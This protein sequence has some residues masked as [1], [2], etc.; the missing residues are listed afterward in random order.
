MIEVGAG[1]R[2]SP[3]AAGSRIDTVTQTCARALPP[4]YRI[5]EYEIV[6]VLGAGGFGITYLANDT[7]LDGPVALKEYFPHEH[8]ERTAGQHVAALPTEESRALFTWGL[9]RFVD[10]ARSI[11]RFRHPNVVRV[12][13]YVEALG[14]ACIVME[15]V[16]GESLDAVLRTRAPLPAAEWRQWLDRLLDGLE[17]VHGHGYVHRDITP[18]NIV[19]RAANGEPVFIDFA[20]ARA[21]ARGRAHTQVLTPRYA[22]I[23]QHGTE[24]AQGPPTDIY[25]LA[26]VSY[27]A[28]T[29][30]C[31][32]E[33]PARAVDD[34]YEPLA[35]RVAGADLPWLAAIDRGMA[36]RPDDRPRTVSAW[37]SAMAG[38][39][40]PERAPDE[41]AAVSV[42][43]LAGD[44]EALRAS[45]ARHTF[46]GI[47]FGTS[48]TVV[49]IARMDDG[50]RVP[51]AEPLS[52]PQ[53][54][55]DGRRH[56]DHLVP[57]CL[58][59]RNG[60]LLVGRGVTTHLKARLREGVDHWSSFK[61]ELGVDL[62]PQYPNTVLAKGRAPVV[63]ERPQDA[64]RVFLSH[65]RE[66]VD[67]HVLDHSLPPPVYAVSVPAAFEANQR[68]DLV[69]ALDGAGIPVEDAGL[70][71]E[72]NAAFLSYV[73][74]MERGAEGPSVAALLP[75]K[76][77][78]VL[79]FDF[80]AG[81]CDISVLEVS[82]A[83]GRLSSRNLAISKFLALGGD[84][85]DRAIAERML[86]FQLRGDADPD[87]V[88]SSNER[89]KLLLPRLKSVAEEL[90]IQCSKQAEAMK[91]GDPSDLRDC[92]DPIV[93]DPIEAIEVRGK[94][95]VLDEPQVTLGE[96]AEIMEPFLAAAA[97]P[98]GDRPDRV[99]SVL[100]PV[101]S[102]LEKAGLTP[103]DLDMVL[104]IGGSSANPLVRGA[105]ER[106]VG[107]FVECVAPRDLRAHVS[108]GAAIHSLYLHGL[109]HDV[110]RPIT[111]EPIYVLTRD[112]NQEGVI[113]AGSEVLSSTT[114][115]QETV[116]DAGSPVPSPTT[117]TSV[118]V[119]RDRQ[120]RVELPFCVGGRDKILAV[121]TVPPPSPPG[122]FEKGE[123]I[124]ISSHI[125]R[126]KLLVVKVHAGG[127]AVASEI[128]NPL[129]NAELLPRGRRLLQARQALNVS[130]L[131]GKGR[132]APAAV[133]TYAHA[134]QE[135]H[136]WR[137]AAEM[138]EAAERLD[139]DS[140]HAISISYN[141]WSCRDYRRSREWSLK[142]HQRAPSCVTA[143]NCAL[144]ER[145]SGDIEACAR[146]MEES[147]RLDPDYV[148]A[149][150]V[151][152]HALR[153]DSD[154]RGLE[155]VTRAF[156]LL[157]EELE[158]G[159]LSKDDC[160]LLERN[161][162]T[163]GKRRTLEH[164][165]EYRKRWRIDDDP[166]DPD[167]LAASRPDRGERID[168]R[169]TAGAERIEL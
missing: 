55:E 103:D 67:R 17:H 102:A 83:D 74:D 1:V 144:D 127:A 62:G 60:R 65:L 119:G 45:L 158:R 84:D 19:I 163:L 80:G 69:R 54:D 48:T 56:D 132:P 15:Y 87:D 13:R 138:Y 166:V 82:I 167:V 98:G 135:A 116:I 108:Q 130:I 18:A 51:R 148:P 50:G 151:H 40:G 73:F 49:S 100:D 78:R 8:A 7:R 24:G 9:D 39:D 36:L 164:V 104:F 88:L 106:H 94:S 115:T 161:A 125:S 66:A 25:A 131:A 146:L 85:I 52:V 121:L 99:P 21:A 27:R 44:A 117:I 20:A 57:S 58:A 155:Y 109:E 42:T 34:R 111:S 12:H 30:E 71:D 16:E 113:D 76:P 5:E 61:M 93:A 101:S 140:D 105:I 147:L 120:A 123:T 38:A 6:R 122:W 92:A 46:V 77:R 22:P 70:I 97:S 96:F 134:A 153:A 156:D 139:P 89:D 86:L 150:T 165:R 47:D 43:N 53:F 41:A 81:T 68:R 159:S 72:P 124:R 107:R 91:A 33:A 128:L 162:R 64:A 4:G 79:V 152:G 136:R 133:L 145:R 160:D 3:A 63:V 129:A 169:T 14:T 11:H 59:W 29:G 26:A 142:A 2:N 110:V 114:I 75:K 154:P 90:K 10:E 112:D 149:L 35:G 118:T 95:W 31:A 143:F 137:E 37:R 168:R 126:D 28:L 141:Y 157:E 23:E 32:P